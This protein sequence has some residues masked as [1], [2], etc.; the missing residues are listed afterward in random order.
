MVLSVVWYKVVPAH[1]GGQKG[2][3][4]FSNYLAKHIPLTMVCSSNNKPQGDEAFRIIPALPESKTQFVSPAAWKVAE[5]ALTHTDAKYLLLE[6]CYYGLFG[7]WMK[8]TR[9]IKLIV[10]SHNIEYLRFKQRKT[11]WWLI[12]FQVEKETHR[13][14]H[15]SLFKTE[16]DLQHAIHKFYLDPAKCMV[17]PYGLERTQ[18]PTAEEKL[19]ASQTLRTRHNIL[20]NQK[21][22][23]FNGTLDYQPNALALRSI[24]NNILPLLSP[25]HV[26]IVCGRI[27]DKG[28]EDIASFSAPNYINA[29]YVDDIETYFMGSDVFVNPVHTGGGVKVKVM[30]ALSFGLPVIT[31][32]SGASGIRQDLTGDL[33][34][35]V[36]DGNYKAFAEAILNSQ[37]RS[38]I[39]E[40]FFVHYHW[41]GITKRVAERIRELG[42]E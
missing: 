13:A 6:H 17:V 19:Q 3:A 22:L 16:E 12:L 27:I 10:H 28:F 1:F 9:G 4:L 38:G 34:T 15:L 14:A 11:W 5:F 23:L 37:Y 2:I 41:D 32:S 40:D 18:L 8:K 39:G 35:L 7:M 26:V 36:E 24:F 33:L 21:I 42:V 25:D 29:G 20:D 30:E 31:Y